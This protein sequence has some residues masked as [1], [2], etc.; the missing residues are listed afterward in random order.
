VIAVAIF[1]TVIAVTEPCD[2]A[3]QHEHSQPFWEANGCLA[4]RQIPLLSSA[5]H[6]WICLYIVSKVVPVHAV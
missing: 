2:Q 3:H 5:L 1:C 6:K 4:D